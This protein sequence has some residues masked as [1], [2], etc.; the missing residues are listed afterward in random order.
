MNREHRQRIREYKRIWAPAVVAVLVLVVFISVF[1]TYRAAVGQAAKI[2]VNGQP[3]TGSINLAEHGL[4]AYL[5]LPEGS[6]TS[7]QQFSTVTALGGISRSYVWELSQLGG[8]GTIYSYKITTSDTRETRAIDPIVPGEV[9]R[10][11][12]DLNDA[13]PD[14]EI[15]YQDNQ[16]TVRNLHFI[17]PDK[18]VISIFN[19]ETNVD[20]PSVIR[21]S[22]G[23]T[24]SARVKAVSSTQPN[25][26]VRFN[27]LLQNTPTSAVPTPNNERVVEVSFPVPSSA[28]ANL[29]EV[30]ATVGTGATAVETKAYYL[31]S[32]GNRAFLLQKESFPATIV[33]FTA[34]SG[35]AAQFQVV[36]Q[37][38][39]ELQP[40]AIPCAVS[41]PISTFFK[42][43]DVERIYAYQDN[44]I[45]VWNAGPTV[46]SD[47]VTFEPFKGYY[48]KLKESAAT[49]TDQLERTFG[50]ACAVQTLTPEAVETR[51]IPLGLSLLSLPGVVELPLSEFISAADLNSIEL[52]ECVTP[53]SCT[54]I[55]STAELNPGKPY[56][57]FNGGQQAITMRYKVQ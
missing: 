16:I 29:L 40:L 5:T 13:Q 41:T 34:A 32:V 51:L 56:W 44:K 42:D 54:E 57:I 24:F 43:L 15:S 55:P 46:P 36:L 7:T 35:S 2:Q 48:V 52:L 45:L 49:A 26:A 12:L 53:A 19:A 39:A 37:P 3:P 27:G 9:V 8:T 18:S 11:H 31:V 20:Y 4:F 17:S 22:P 6:E 28:S 30:I 50:G 38:T 47:L 14:L 33:E 21:L 23:G 1:F 25:I 10:L